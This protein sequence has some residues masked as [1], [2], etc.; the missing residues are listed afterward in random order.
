MSAPTPPEGPGRW[1]LLQEM[2]GRQMWQQDEAAGPGQTI[3]RFVIANP[4]EILTYD[5]FDEA[6]AMFEALN[7]DPSRG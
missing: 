2:F 1:T 5:D 3:S 6:Q 7:G 4:P